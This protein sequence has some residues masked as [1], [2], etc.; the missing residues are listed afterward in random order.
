[1]G[2]SKK[3]QNSAKTNRVASKVLADKVNKPSRQAV[4]GGR[5]AVHSRS[6]RR[7]G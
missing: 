1:M 7:G 4:K 5:A 3:M 6:V 2:R